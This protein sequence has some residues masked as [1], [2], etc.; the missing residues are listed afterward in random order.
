MPL[1]TIRL[2]VKDPALTSQSAAWD[3]SQQTKQPEEELGA[4]DDERSDDG[5]YWGD[6]VQRQQMQE[7]G[8][9][10]DEDR[11]E[12]EAQNR[13]D[14]E[15]EEVELTS[16]VAEAKARMKEVMSLARV[17]TKEG[18]N[19]AKEEWEEDSDS[20][21][22]EDEGSEYEVSISIIIC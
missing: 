3:T 15:D 21:E 5:N 17:A 16:F 2:V 8:L 19:D 1:R 12:E 10:G 4:N 13:E 11:D 18:P 20:S 9:M 14:A 6:K 22:S 7:N